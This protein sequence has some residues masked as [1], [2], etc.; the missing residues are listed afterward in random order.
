MVRER[1]TT[2]GVE[3]GPIEYTGRAFLQDAQDAMGGDIVR[4]LVELITNA[5]DAYSRMTKGAVRGRITVEVEH[6]RGKPW[7]AVVRDRATGMSREELRD[8]IPRLGGRSSGFER[9][10]NVRGNRGRGAKDLVAF[11]EVKFESVC[12]EQYSS[13]VLK[14]DGQYELSSSRET[15]EALR[16]ELGIRRGN[17]TVVTVSCLAIVRCPHHQNLMEQLQRHYQLRDIMSDPNREVILVNLNKQQE[18]EK[19]RYGLNVDSLMEVVNEVLAVEGYLEA[20]AH[21]RLWRLPERCEKPRSDPTRPCGILIAGGRAIYDNTLAS[22][23]GNRHVGWYAGRLD[24]PYIDRLAREYDDREEGGVP[25]PEDNPFQIIGR[26]RDNLAPNHPFSI[27]LYGLLDRFLQERV[28]AEEEREREEE[29][30]IESPSTRI[31]LDQMAREAARFLLEA[32][33]E[34]EAEEPPPGGLGEVEGLLIVPPEAVLRFGEERTLSVLA[35]AE[36]LEEGC[37]VNITMEPQG[38]VD[39]LDGPTVHLSKHSRR[40][41][42]LSAQLHLRPLVEGEVLLCATVEDRE[43]LGLVRVSLPIAEELEVEEVPETLMFERPQY[44]VRWHKRKKLTLK[45]PTSLV[46]EY[47]SVVRIATDD[48]GLVIRGGN[49]VRLSPNAE[50]GI[51]Y[52]AVEVEGRELGTKAKITA[53]L[54]DVEAA[55]RVSVEQRDEGLPNLRIRLTPG[56]PGVYRALFDPPEVGPGELQWLL[57]FA[58]HPSLRQY[59]GDP[60]DYPRQDNAEWRAVLAE[61]VTEAV[62]RRII[63]HKYPA[64]RE[65]VDADKVYYDHFA[66]A[67][68][69]LPLMQKLAQSYPIGRS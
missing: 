56:R 43:A 6:R 21:L 16:D 7:K 50:T 61:V 12:A 46:E 67:G 14:Q 34:I 33:R 64:G 45:A 41:D 3:T 62:V 1:I 11:G 31:R 10:L 60:P 54:R 49:S 25:H 35:R 59:L 57:V 38:I 22:F 48:Q 28:E 18:K 9:G 26:R 23:E 27:A 2:K 42:V 17:G 5:D 40:E 32:M 55:C 39:L 20:E 36:G 66:F 13:I 4:G 47:G 68:R 37:E 51:A 52:A 19:L 69:L 29:Q 44:R 15:D 24:C 30:R 8:R 63:T 53:K 65:D 58:E